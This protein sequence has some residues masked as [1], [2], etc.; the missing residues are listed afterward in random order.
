MC[1]LLSPRA[2]ATFGRKQLLYVFSRNPTALARDKAAYFFFFFTP[3]LANLPRLT[4]VSKG[5]LVLPLARTPRQRGTSFRGAQLEV[6]ET[7]M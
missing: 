7:S 6:Q 2:T 4:V 3:L 5:S 1:P